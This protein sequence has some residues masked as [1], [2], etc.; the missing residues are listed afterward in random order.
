[1]ESLSPEAFLDHLRGQVVGRPVSYR[2]LAANS[3]LVY[4]DC[5]PGDETGVMFWFEPT[6]HFRGPE[7][8]LTGSRQAQEDAEAEDPT[9]GFYAAAQAL[10]ALRGRT[11][12]AVQ[13]EAITHSLILR[14][15]G[16]YEVR[17]FVSDPTSD[18]DWHIDE[19]ATRRSLEGCAAGLEFIQ[20]T[21]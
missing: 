14:L 7:R 13:V 18:L 10:D 21:A 12:E 20:R 17:T 4:V 19:N 2:R 11:V 5:E 15:E 8:V 16:G 3:L 9:A 6:W 1:M